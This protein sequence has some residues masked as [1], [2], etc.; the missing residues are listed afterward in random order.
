[1]PGSPRIKSIRKVRAIRG[2]FLRSKKGVNQL[3]FQVKGQEYFLAFVEDER[4]W[5]VFCGNALGMQR[6]PVYV[7]A[8]TYE[9]M[10]SGYEVPKMSS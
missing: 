6:I 7:D 5:Y 1:L 3:Q 10:P 4:R 8:A 9:R 2:L